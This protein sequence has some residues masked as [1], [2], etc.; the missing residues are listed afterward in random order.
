MKKERTKTNQIENE[1]TG[2]YTCRF[3]SEFHNLKNRIDILE[4]EMA[5]QKALRMQN[6]VK[7]DKDWLIYQVKE[8]QLKMMREYLDDLRVRANIERIDLN[9]GE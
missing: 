4:S 3:R 5:I 2:G 8:H 6:A 7:D 9:P 1:A